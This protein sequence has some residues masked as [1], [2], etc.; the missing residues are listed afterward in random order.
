MSTS[1]VSSSCVNSSSTTHTTLFCAICNITCT[2][3]HKYERHI[4]GKQHQKKSKHT[5]T[6]STTPVYTPPVLIP[7]SCFSRSSSTSS[8]SIPPLSTPFSSSCAICSVVFHSVTDRYTH[9]TSRSHALNKLAFKRGME[10]G[11]ELAFA[12]IKHAADMFKQ[13]N[14][15]ISKQNNKQHTT[16]DS[17]SSS[18]SSPS[19]P[20][21]SLDSNSSSLSLSMPSSSSSSSSMSVPTDAAQHLSDSTTSTPPIFHPTPHT[22]MMNNIHK[23]TTGEWNADTVIAK[24]EQEL[25]AM[26]QIGETI[27]QGENKEMNEF[28]QQMST[29]SLL[30]Q[31]VC[32]RNTC[33]ALST[34]IWQ[35]DIDNEWLSFLHAT[36]RGI[37]SYAFYRELKTQE[38]MMEG[39]YGSF[40]LMSEGMEMED[41]SRFDEVD[42]LMYYI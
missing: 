16:S 34:S 21:S 18:T 12:Q 9:L 29:C 28:I 3:Q 22:S 24:Q 37:Q 10:V 4:Q 19:R 2:N 35:Q 38:G 8:S 15:I 23:Q 5:V 41:A 6:S 32:Y 31:D 33:H 39:E 30:Q 26:S 20:L 17:S 42:H 11:I 13:D 25:H 40:E 1:F 36:A 14:I 27:A 7:F